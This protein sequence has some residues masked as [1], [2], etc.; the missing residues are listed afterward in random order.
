MMKYKSMFIM[1]RAL[2]LRIY[3]RHLQKP[4]GVIKLH[5]NKLVHHTGGLLSHAFCS[6]R[7]AAIES[8]G[9]GHP[10]LSRNHDDT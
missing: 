8:A 1:G 7:E 6:E 9:V 10:R 3:G 4:A 2:I 5:F